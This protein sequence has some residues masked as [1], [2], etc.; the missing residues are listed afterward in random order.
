MTF[1]PIVFKNKY[2]YLFLKTMGVTCVTCHISIHFTI[3][4]YVKRCDAGV[5]NVSRLLNEAKCIKFT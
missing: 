3:D 4:Y 2:I 5:C 1:T